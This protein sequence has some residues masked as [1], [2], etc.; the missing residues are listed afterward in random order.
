MLLNST[1]TPALMRCHI[2]NISNKKQAL[3]AISM[4]ISE[5][6]T[7]IKSQDV[8]ESL[9]KRERLGSTA[10]GYG[11]AIPH[12]RIKNL[13]KATCVI[14]TLATPVDFDSAEEIHNQPVDLLFSLLVPEDA[15]QAHLDILS[16]I[17]TKL[18]DKEYRDNLR[19]ASSSQSLY[20]AAIDH[21]STPHHHD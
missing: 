20:A 7:R 10:I 21:T 2:P 4:L 14:V 12:A 17:A 6:D 8:L 1:L 3:E 9:Q 16:E 18:K 15:T 11:V 19:A 5:A 13:K